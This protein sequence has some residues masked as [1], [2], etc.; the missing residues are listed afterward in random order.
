M[1]SFAIAVGCDELS[2]AR[3]RELL[4]Q[5]CGQ[6][7]ADNADKADKSGQKRTKAPRSPNPVGHGTDGAEKKSGRSKQKPLAK[8][9]KPF[10]A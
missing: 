2:L 4:P 5:K 3:G 8:S 10:K 7:K 6:D 9:L 1:G